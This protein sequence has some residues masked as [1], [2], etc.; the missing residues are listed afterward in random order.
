MTGPGPAAVS[1]T[2]PACGAGMAF[3]AEANILRCPYC[4]HEMVPA[5]RWHAPPAPT[6]QPPPDDEDTDVD[7][8]VHVATGAPTGPPA[9][10]LFAVVSLLVVF[11]ILGYFLIWPH[12]LRPLL[13][14]DR[15]V[16]LNEATR[17]ESFDVTVTGVDCGKASV[18]GLDESEPVAAEGT[19][20]LIT[21]SVRNVGEKTDSYPTYDLK[22]VSATEREFD[23]NSTAE[24]YANRDKRL[25]TEPIDP[26]RTVTEVLVFDVPR[27]SAVAFL[28]LNDKFDDVVVK[29]KLT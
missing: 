6:W 16:A 2:C 1:S 29:V 26:G 22:A 7:L 24:S 4:R 27:D 15:V 23:R 19:F 28:M 20:C 25:L 3:D 5:A 9:S 17:V 13:A 10:P 11:S 8:V 12:V 21:L 14:S 18:T